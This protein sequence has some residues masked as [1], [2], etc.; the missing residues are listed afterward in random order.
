MPHTLSSPDCNYFG[1]TVGGPL[2]PIG[3]CMNFQ[4]TSSYAGSHQWI[5]DGSEGIST[6]VYPDFDCQGSASEYSF[7]PKIHV[8]NCKQGGNICDYV[9]WREYPGFIFTD[10]GKL[11]ECQIQNKTY[12]R[13]FAVVT[14]CWDALDVTYPSNKLK[15]NHSAITL[16]EY[17]STGCVDSQIGDQQTMFSGCDTLKGNN[18]TWT[19]IFPKYNPWI[20]GNQSVNLT[21]GTNH[22]YVDILDCV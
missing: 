19:P 7:K 10:D 2:F 6:L 15:C 8:I 12:Y 9:K 18:K 14:G 3:V 13:D 5:C 16:T 11:P 20:I 1:T 21:Y 22:T 17:Y 4:Y